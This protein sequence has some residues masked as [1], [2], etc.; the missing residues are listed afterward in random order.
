MGLKRLSVLILINFFLFFS[1]FSFAENSFKVIK[2]RFTTNVICCP[3]YIYGIKRVL[4]KTEGIKNFYTMTKRGIAVIAYYPDKISKE[5]IIK[6]VK[7]ARGMRF[8]KVEE[9]K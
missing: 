8:V 2:L 3:V 6:R 5:E 9:V 1:S 7:S 4:K